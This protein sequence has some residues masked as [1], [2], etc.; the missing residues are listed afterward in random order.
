MYQDLKNL[1]LWPGMKR[2]VAEFVFACLVRQKFKTEHQ[3]L[4]GMMQPLF[5]LE[6]KWDSILMDFVGALSKTATGYDS[7]CVVID[8]LSKSAH[9][10]PIKTGLFMEKVAEIYIKQVVRLHSVLSSIVLD[11]DS[12]FT[13]KFWESLQEALGTKLRSSSA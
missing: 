8:R 3:K 6:W 13:S 12:R 1:F 4:S 7:I 9:F 2:D 5:V 10:I 11:R